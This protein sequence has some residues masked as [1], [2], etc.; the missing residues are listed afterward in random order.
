MNNY[1]NKKYT[2]TTKKKSKKTNM[3]EGQEK[4]LV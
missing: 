1:N 2:K 3:P 4:A